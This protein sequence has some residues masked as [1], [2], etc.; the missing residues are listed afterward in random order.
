MNQV[1]GAGA[2][3]GPLADPQDPHVPGQYVYTRFPHLGFIVFRV[4]PPPIYYLRQGQFTE[5][6]VFTD[7]QPLNLLMWSFLIRKPGV[8]MLICICIYKCMYA[9]I[10]VDV[11][12]DV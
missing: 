11:D 2:R 6:H 7:T 8:R 4:S 3:A 5:L 12:V 9:C 10:R 1:R